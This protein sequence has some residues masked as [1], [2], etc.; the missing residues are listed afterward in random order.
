M[1]KFTL[2]FGSFCVDGSMILLLS[3]KFESGLVLFP[4]KI[5]MEPIEIFYI[6]RKSL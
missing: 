6:P 4:V 2:I 5:L 3:I 1:W